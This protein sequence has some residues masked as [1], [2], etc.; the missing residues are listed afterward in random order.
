MPS[1][2]SPF[3]YPGGKSQLYP[4]VLNLLH[5][6]QPIDTYIEPFAGGSGIGLKLLLNGKVKR[7]VI[8]DFDPAIYSVWWS[9]MRHPDYLIDQIMAVPFDYYNP[10]NQE[11]NIHF[12]KY[13]Q[14]LF[15]QNR[16]NR[17]SLPGAFA[18]LFLNRTNRSGIIS[19]GPIGGWSQAGT[20]ISVRFNKQTLIRKI[21]HIYEYRHKITIS[22]MDALSLIPTISTAYS[23]KSTFIFFDPP[24]YDQGSNL[25]FSS[26]DDMGHQALAKLIL[27]LKQ[28][29]WIVTYDEEPFIR[30]L[31][32]SASGRY[33]YFINYSASSQNRG[34]S[35]EYL[36][37]SNALQVE[38]FDKT[39]LSGID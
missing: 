28:F 23:S 9:I 36:F 29:K 7:I 30:D 5:L 31:Y 2:Y 33:E 18:T 3:R 15:L 22:N 20:K 11:E 19:G 1:T 6:N 27:S 25:Y 17:H 39:Q 10:G 35:Q 34:K 4:F 21:E 12:W 26:L 16:K 32:V 38:S 14:A 24:Y 13:Q 37:S 8:N